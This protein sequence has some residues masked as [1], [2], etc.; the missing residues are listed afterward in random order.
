MFRQPRHQGINS[1]YTFLHMLYSQPTGKY[2]QYL[3]I[4][5]PRLLITINTD[6]NIVVKLNAQGPRAQRVDITRAYVHVY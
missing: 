3:E 4:L 5:V 1:C 6:L 2:V